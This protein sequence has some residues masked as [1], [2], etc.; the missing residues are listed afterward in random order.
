M[1]DHASKK[2]KFSD[3]LHMRPEFWEDGDKTHHLKCKNCEKKG[4]RCFGRNGRAC[5]HCCRGRV[6]CTLSAGKATAATKSTAQVTHD[7]GTRRGPKPFPMSTRMLASLV[8][9]PTSPRIHGQKSAKRSSSDDGGTEQG[10]IVKKCKTSHMEILD[11][12]GCSN[13]PSMVDDSANAFPQTA[14]RNCVQKLVF[15]PTSN[16]L[17]SFESHQLPIATQRGWPKTIDFAKVP[18]RVQEMKKELEAIV[19]DMDVSPNDG[20]GPR[21]KSTFWIQVKNGVK[22]QGSRTMLAVKGQFTSFEKSQPGYYGEQG[23]AIIHQTLFDL[24]PPSAFNMSLVEPLTLIEFIQLVLVPEV[25]I[26]L[27]AEDLSVNMDEAL[28]TLHDSAK[29]GVGMFPDMSENC[30]DEDK[31]SVADQIAMER[32]RARRKELIEEE[33]TVNVVNGVILKA[34][35]SSSPDA[36]YA[37]HIL[38]AAVRHTKGQL[39]A[40]GVADN[41]EEATAG[42]SQ[43]KS[44]RDQPHRTQMKEAFT[45]EHLPSKNL[46]ESDLKSVFVNGRIPGSEVLDELPE[47]RKEEEEEDDNDNDTPAARFIA[48]LLKCLLKGFIAKD[49]VVRY[50]CVRLLTETVARLGEVEAA[51]IERIRDK[52]TPIRVQA[53]VTF[54]KLCGSEDPSDADEREQTAV[55]VLPNALS[56]DPTAGHLACHSRSLARH[57]RHHAS[58]GLFCGPR[59]NC[60]T[61]DDSAIGPLHPRLLTTAQRELIVCKGLGDHEPAVHSAAGS[62]LG[63]WVNVVRGPTKD[64]EE[65]SLTENAVAE[66]AL[67]SIFATRVDIVYHLEFKGYV[68]YCIATNDQAKLD[69]AIPVVTHLSHHVRGVRS[70]Y[71]E[72]VDAFSQERALPTRQHGRAEF[73]LSEML[74]LNYADE[75]GWR[76]LFQLES[77]PEGLMARRLDVLRVLSPSERDLIRAVV[78][79]VHE[80]RDEREDEGDEGEKNGEGGGAEDDATASAA[81]A[82]KA[83]KPPKKLSPEEQARTDE[84]DLRCLSLCIGMLERVNGVHLQENS[85]LEGILGELILPAVKQKELTLHEKGLRMALNSFQLF[86]P[87]AQSTPEVLK[88]CMLQIV[89]DMLMIHKPDFFGL[90]LE[91]MISDERVRFCWTIGV[92]KCLVVAYL[93]PDMADNQEL[94]QCLA[95]FFSVDCYSSSV[96]QK[97]MRQISMPTFE[98][99]ADATRDLED[100]QEMV[101]PAQI[102]GTFA[103]WS[104]PQKAMWSQTIEDGLHLNLAENALK[105]LFK[106]DIHSMSSIV[107][108][109]SVS[110]N[111]DGTKV[112]RQ[113]LGRLHLPDKV[114]DDRPEHQHEQLCSLSLEMQ[115]VVTTIHEL[116]GFSCFL[117]PSLSSDLQCAAS[118]GP[119]IV[120]NA[121][122]YSCDALVVMLGRDPF[123]VTAAFLR[124]M[125]QIVSP[126]IDFLRMTHPLRSRIWWCPAAEFSVLPLHAACPYRK[127]QRSLPDLYTV[128]FATQERRFVAIGQAKAAGERKLPSVGAELANI[129]QLVSDLVPFNCSPREYG[130]LNPVRRLDVEAGECPRSTCASK[131]A[132]L[133]DALDFVVPSA[134]GGAGSAIVGVDVP[135]E[136]FTDKTARH[137]RDRLSRIFMAVKVH[138]KSAQPRG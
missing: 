75:I 104:G 100:Y 123:R 27:I 120:V 137:R 82:P 13:E 60:T 92:L 74:K 37:G 134:L 124:E 97:W 67:L 109:I 112:L 9:R 3:Q 43:V 64:D 50:H 68:E 93:S 34:L 138:I 59:E 63:A 91:G 129:G 4:Q 41:S 46:A 57:G 121:S 23:S 36:C 131:T 54:C 56:C 125:D 85:T 51:F 79:V 61:K 95:Y 2:D 96:N 72:D 114:D 31:M 8:R 33:S 76:N 118:D 58:P 7:L 126:I 52:E 122:Q 53:A 127:G 5:R 14:S 116:T 128:P 6:K 12:F 19:L 17:P 113:I 66:D 30:A 108:R 73:V 89:F 24:F 88:L 106:D 55:D 25:A 38:D 102:I 81:K 18:A 107:L 22:K 94:R 71:Q 11:A 29:Y 65:T 136:R 10:F 135:I 70:K 48:R 130:S 32:A 28:R 101:S 115:R 80:L 132:S 26:R 110:A 105:T 87:Q 35:F 78:E 119:V 40:R 62:L 90:M 39:D 16:K 20:V 21:S 133:R 42:C 45:T 117:L 15:G 103:D 47:T 86:L 49:K 44:L 69:V 99:L 111:A 1:S 77:L 84:L 83:P 98:Q